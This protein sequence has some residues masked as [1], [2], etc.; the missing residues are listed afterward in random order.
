MDLTLSKLNWELKLFF[1]DTSSRVS[2]ENLSDLLIPGEA[3][4]FFIAVYGWAPGLFGDN[5]TYLCAIFFERYD[6]VHFSSGV[7]TVKRDFWIYL[8]EKIEKLLKINWG[9]AEPGKRQALA[10]WISEKKRTLEISFP[11]K[12]LPAVVNAPPKDIRGI[13][14]ED[15]LITFEQ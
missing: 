6:K 13:I 2:E 12:R 4:D 14:I 3:R 10:E 1:L 8:I 11:D 5:G 15:I 9:N 7:H